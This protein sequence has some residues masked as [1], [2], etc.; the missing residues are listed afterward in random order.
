VIANSGHWLMDEQTAVTVAA[1]RS[2]LDKK[3]PG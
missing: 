3:P 2:F 1:I